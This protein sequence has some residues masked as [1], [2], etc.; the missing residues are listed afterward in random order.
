MPRTRDKQGG[1]QPSRS[2]PMEETDETQY[3][4]VCDKG[5][6]RKEPEAWE[7]GRWGL[8]KHKPGCTPAYHVPVLRKAIT[9]QFPH[10]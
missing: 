10:L 8:G 2:C 9:T 1:S 7:A 5:P 4:M 6:K 3:S